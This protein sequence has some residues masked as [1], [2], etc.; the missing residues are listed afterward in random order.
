MSA[1]PTIGSDRRGFRLEYQGRRPIRFSRDEWAGLIYKIFVN[2]PDKEFRQQTRIR[3][4]NSGSSLMSREAAILDYSYGA[5]TYP[6]LVDT[7]HYL[8]QD[9]TL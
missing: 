9:D 3:N 1:I 5:I 6:Q 4:V 7:L 8:T 2:M